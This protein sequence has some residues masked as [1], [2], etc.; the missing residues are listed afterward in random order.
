[1]KNLLSILFVLAY[2][3]TAFAGDQFVICNDGNG[4][5]GIEVAHEYETHC[6]VGHEESHRQK[7]NNS[8]HK[9][10]CKPCYDQSIGNENLVI[11]KL[12]AFEIDSILSFTGTK[13]CINHGSIPCFEQKIYSN[14]PP[15]LDSTLA[16]LRTVILII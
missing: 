13:I 1:M 10:N 15:R 14:P 11:S 2:A 6:A 8:I 9:K 12:E 16:S 3:L 5:S 4:H 7:K